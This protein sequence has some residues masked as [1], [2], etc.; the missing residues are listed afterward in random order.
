MK[1][2]LLFFRGRTCGVRGLTRC[3][4][5]RGGWT[6]ALAAA[7]I[8]FAFL[9]GV[10][11]AQNATGTIYFRINSTNAGWWDVNRNLVLAGT[12]HALTLRNMITAIANQDFTDGAGVIPLKVS[13][14]ANSGAAGKVGMWAADSSFLYVCYAGNQWARI[15]WSSVSF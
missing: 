2:K 8:V 10:V 11:S 1:S 9:P 4:A 3:S 14:P 12:T 5:F 13:A 7:L 15:A 6:I